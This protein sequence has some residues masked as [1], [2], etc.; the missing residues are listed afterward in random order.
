MS[1]PIPCPPHPTYCELL[2]LL[3]GARCSLRKLPKLVAEG[4]SRRRKEAE[5]R[6]EVPCCAPATA[7][8]A[9]EA[10]RDTNDKQQRGGHQLGAATLRKGLQR[11]GTSEGCRHRCARGSS[12]EEG[13]AH[14]FIPEFFLFEFGRCWGHRCHALG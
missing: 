4:G 14:L 3:V 6:R 10:R 1:P 7:K 8:E 11:G 5:E 9:A 2:V 13:A 12:W